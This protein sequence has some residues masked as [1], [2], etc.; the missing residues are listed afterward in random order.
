MSKE[1][2]GIGFLS[3]T[4]QYGL[5]FASLPVLPSVNGSP[6]YLRHWV[7]GS[8]PMYPSLSLS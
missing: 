4:L 2:K 8:M 6:L 3:D 5:R 1:N 7:N